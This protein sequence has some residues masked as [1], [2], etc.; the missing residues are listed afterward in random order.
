MKEFEV[1]FTFAYP[2]IRWLHFLQIKCSGCIGKFVKNVK[3][4]SELKLRETRRK[5][6]KK[7][8]SHREV[9]PKHPFLHYDTR[10][11]ATRNIH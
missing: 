10:L 8:S 7:V 11:Y 3:A 5:S 4:N 6:M 1:Q 9:K 2:I